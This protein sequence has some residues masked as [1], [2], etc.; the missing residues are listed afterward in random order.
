MKIRCVTNSIRLRLRKSE[1]A[2][3]QEQGEV[4]ESINFGPRTLSYRLRVH[5]ALSQSRATFEEDLIDV[6]LPQAEAD[7]WAT[8]EQVSIEHWLKL[9]EGEQLH[10]LVEKD[11]PCKDRPEEDQSD[12]FFELASEEKLAC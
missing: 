1:L 5:A 12:T 2:T 7:R 8:T 4:V 6:V 10:L 3:L 9:S 11:F